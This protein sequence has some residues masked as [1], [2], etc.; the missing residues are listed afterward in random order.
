MVAVHF[1]GHMVFCQAYGICSE[2]SRPIIETQF[3]GALE[4]RHNL[5]DASGAAQTARF[6][7][8]AILLSWVIAF[9]I[10]CGSGEDAAEALRRRRRSEQMEKIAGDTSPTEIPL[11]V[12][13]LSDQV[14]AEKED[15]S[16]N[17]IIS[18]PDSNTFIKLPFLPPTTAEVARLASDSTGG[19]NLNAI[20]GNSID[21][22]DSLA[23][24]MKIISLKEPHDTNRTNPG[25]L[26]ANVCRECHQERHA[27]FVHTAHHLTSGWMPI[28]PMVATGEVDQLMA[29]KDGSDS[30]TERPMQASTGQLVLDDAKVHGRYASAVTWVDEHV[31]PAAPLGDFDDP[32][33]F[34]GA[35]GQST[36]ESDLGSRSRSAK[37]MM[38]SS[39]P[40][41]AFQMVHDSDG[42]HQAV[43][44]AD[45]ELQLPVHVYTGSAKAGQTFLYWH[46]QRLYQSFVSYLTELDQWIPS[47]GYFD[48][49]ADFTREIGTT[50]L[51]C[52]VTYIEPGAERGSL[53]PETAVWGISCERCHGPARDH[54][55]YHRTFPDEKVAKHIAQPA[56][57]TRQQQ[58]DICSQC[59]SGSE[60]LMTGRFDFRPGMEGSKAKTRR[61]S[62]GVGGVHTANQLNRLAMSRCFQ[63]SEMTCTT[64]HDPHLNQRG[65]RQVFSKSCL[66]CHTSSHCGMSA[67]IGESISDNCIDCHMPTGDNDQMTIEVG[68]GDRFTVRMIDHY[69]RV[70]RE[71]AEHYLEK[72]LPQTVSAKTD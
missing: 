32:S 36:I 18:Q 50:C 57:L 52:H 38:Q 4:M 69:I 47:P 5:T 10:G 25:F 12:K 42:Y 35:L 41:L 3:L 40:A 37:S 27:S 14:I 67:Q 49:T 24:L 60:S 29:T 33:E 6:L 46:K 23:K 63:N 44:L 20:A 19:S 13:K 58:L 2:N 15:A 55:E 1:A 62:S 22:L 68:G 11:L 31:S 51:E 26:G 21:G 61:V 45:F 34:A 8:P 28:G 16:S 30:E 59:H 53:K 17:W 9:C 54:V 48:T 71:A 7:V 39:D 66:E 65:Q 64:C 56:D 43:R 70:D 72:E